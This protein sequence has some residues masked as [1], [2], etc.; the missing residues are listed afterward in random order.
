MVNDEIE[1]YE[2]RLFERA[3]FE[4]ILAYIFPL[5]VREQ[6]LRM[7]SWRSYRKRSWLP[8]GKHVWHDPKSIQNIWPEQNV[9]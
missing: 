7:L 5:Q 9:S 6:I 2:I 4:T 1:G 3:Y 8:D